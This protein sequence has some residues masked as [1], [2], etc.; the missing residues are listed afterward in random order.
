MFALLLAA[1]TIGDGN[2][3]YTPVCAPLLAW[4]MLGERLTCAA[5]R[6]S[7]RRSVA[8]RFLWTAPLRRAPCRNARSVLQG[9]AAAPAFGLGTVVAKQR[10]LAMSSVAGLAWQALFGALLVAAVALFEHRDRSRL[11]MV[12]IAIC[13][14]VAVMPLTAAYLARVRALAYVPASLATTTIPLSPTI[15]VIVPAL[16]PDELLGP[17]QV[18]ALVLTLTG[19]AMATTR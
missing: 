1:A 5:L 17:G 14:C 6:R 8:W 11:N 13:G 9:F 15:G 12:D 4:P 3:S 7:C 10:R 18:V 16:K 2:Q 19:V